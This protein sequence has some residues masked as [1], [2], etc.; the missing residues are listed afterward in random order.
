MKKGDLLAVELNG[1]ILYKICESDESKTRTGRRFVRVR[2]G[3]R[4]LDGIHP[5]R[6]VILRSGEVSRLY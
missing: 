3:A 4:R 6:V 2:T 1:E 5:S